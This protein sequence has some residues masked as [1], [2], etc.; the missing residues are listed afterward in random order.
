MGKRVGRKSRIRAGGAI[1]AILAIYLTVVIWPL[2][3]YF[4]R[5][6]PSSS[7]N[8]ESPC[9]RNMISGD[10]LQINYFYWIFS[11]M[12]KG[13]TRF[14]YNVYEF[15]TGDD[16]QRYAPGGYN[17]PYSFFYF[18]GNLTG[19]RSMAWNFMLTSMALLSG[20]FCYLYLRQLL[21]SRA[22]ALGLACVH[23][24]F[25]YRWISTMGGSPTGI[26]MVCVPLLALGVHLF[27]AKRRWTGYL[28]ALAALLIVHANEHH[29]FLFGVLTLPLPSLIAIFHGRAHVLDRSGREW[30]EVVLRLAALMTIIVGM[31]LH[32]LFGINEALEGSTV[33]SGRSLKEVAGFSP[34][35][36]GL[37]RWL[38]NGVNAHAFIGIGAIL[39][40]LAFGVHVVLRV[41]R[42]GV[43]AL[44]SDPAILLPALLW[45]FLAGAACY[46]LGTNG[47]FDYLALR[48]ARKLIPGMDL[49]RQPAKLNC[50][51][52][53]FLPVTAAL[54]LM[55]QDRKRR[56]SF[57][58]GIAL[59]LLL[60]IEYVPQVRP[61]VCML[62]P[63]QG[64]YETVHAD[65]QARGV[66]PH[67]VVL[68]LWPGDSSWASLY[69]YYVSLYRI[70]MVNGYRPIVPPTYYEEV[71]NALG[72]LNCG[73]IDEDVVKALRA[74]KID[75]ILFHEDAFP[76]QVCPFPVGFALDQLQRSGWVDRIARD[77]SIWAY[78]VRDV[79][80]T[81]APDVLPREQGAVI[82]FPSR[83]WDFAHGLAEGGERLALPDGGRAAVMMPGSLVCLPYVNAWGAERAAV[84]VR[85]RGQGTLRVTLDDYTCDVPINAADWQWIDLPLPAEPVG[86]QMTIRGISGAAQLGTAFLA[87]GPWRSFLEQ[88]SFTLPASWFYHAGHMNADLSAVCMRRDWEPDDRIWYGLGLPL[89]AGRYAFRLEYASD[90]PAG[91]VLG[92]FQCE[93]GQAVEA[94]DVVGGRQVAECAVDIAEG[95]LPRL[96]FRYT[97]EDDVKLLRVVATRV[98]R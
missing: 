64:A 37:F 60:A 21:V 68:P 98:A 18:V 30:G 72:S 70:R 80:A 14:L 17:V 61:T 88:D 3:R 87:A 13:K 84:T 41:R 97:R 77:G 43:G 48:V 7:T 23:I 51:V 34:Q 42:K 25:P 69:E 91:A 89:P 33:A 5:G 73:Y 12:L 35:A 50:V 32:M 49:I 22:L 57:S 31:G 67:S 16:D 63:R 94:V 58:L 9:A 39:F 6:I 15:N 1:V 20:I 96:S 81:P 75:Y 10:H 8:I 65:A 90:A 93:R 71:F 59:A 45:V 86:G 46:S 2:P 36:V 44:F 76:E 85:A 78:R 11:D 19:N 82:Y 52:A 24:G 40:L 26:S 29:V 27:V 4:T 47:P 38:E 66:V 56:F 53:F 95:D 62:P 74:M 83:F 55:G 92:T 79:R 54:S 28:I